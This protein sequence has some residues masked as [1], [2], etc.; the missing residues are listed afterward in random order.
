MAVHSEPIGEMSDRDDTP[1][2]EDGPTR[3]PA[4]R[5]RER[6]WNNFLRACGWLSLH[7]LLVVGYLTFVFAIGMNWM[8]ALI[9]LFIAGL[10]GGW[11]I[12]LS[13]AWT[14][15][16]LVQAGIVIVARLFVVLFQALL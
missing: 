15:A 10:A 6:M 12:G 9:I 8:T 13:R 1:P 3:M 7:V 14:L 5:P 2:A 11:I 16:M 4:V